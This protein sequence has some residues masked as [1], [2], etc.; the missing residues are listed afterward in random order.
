MNT[1]V[2]EV[3]IEQDDDGRW[4]AEIPLLPGCNAWGYSRE[5]ALEALR[6]TARAFL[7]IML[8]DG[9]PLPAEAREEARFSSAMDVAVADLVTV[10]L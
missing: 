3:D 8:E 4:G 7:E 10:T 9:D 1:Y 2:F 5:Q 6:D